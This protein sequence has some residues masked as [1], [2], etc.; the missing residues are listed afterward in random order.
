MRFLHYPKILK[1]PYIKFISIFNRLTLS[2]RVTFN[3]RTEEDTIMMI[4]RRNV[5]KL[6]I[7]LR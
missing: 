2:Y 1:L 3:Y 6:R 4:I 5:A 7:Q